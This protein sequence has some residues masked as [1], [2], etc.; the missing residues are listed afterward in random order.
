MHFQAVALCL[1]EQAFQ[2]HICLISSEPL[3]NGTESKIRGDVNALSA[4]MGHHVFVL[5]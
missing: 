5:R 1:K 2:L 4:S 3:V